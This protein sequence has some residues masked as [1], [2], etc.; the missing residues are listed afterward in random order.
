MKKQFPIAQTL[1]LKNVPSNMTFE[2]YDEAAIPAHHPILEHLHAINPYY[3][4]RSMKV[5]ILMKWMIKPHNNEAMWIYGPTGSGKTSFATEFL[6]RFRIPYIMVPITKKLKFQQALGAKTIVDGDLAY[7]YGLLV[8]AMLLGIPVILDEGDRWMAEESVGLHDLLQNGRVTIPETGEVIYAKPGFKIIVTANSAGGGDST[9][10]HRVNTQDLAFTERFIFL[11]ME[12]ADKEVE[13]DILLKQ[14]GTV[15]GINIAIEQLLDI[16]QRIR[17]VS[18]ADA[19]NEGQSTDL[20]ISLST[21]KLEH[22]THYMIEHADVKNMGVDPMM[23][24]FEMCL[25]PR[26]NPSTRLAIKEIIEESKQGV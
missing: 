8:N 21:R 7:E 2:G 20:D 14:F 19:R 25:L 16:A 23:F 4:F 9:G 1:G 5:S 15:P 13:K 17:S 22:I 12:Y 24:A 10:L 3:V 26:A 11:E 6:N 18:M